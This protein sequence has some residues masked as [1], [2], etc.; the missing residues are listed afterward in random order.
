VLLADGRLAAAQAQHIVAR[1]LLEDAAD[2]FERSGAAYEA[3]QTRLELAT[4][5]PALG[6]A[7]AALA[8][9]KQA[10]AAVAALGA[11]ERHASADAGPL[12]QR[13]HEVLRLVAQGRSNDEIAAALVLSVRTV[14]RHVA[15]AYAKIGVSGRTARAAATAWAHANAIT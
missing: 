1:A 6:Y 14:E 13:E 8:A 4:S 5:L 7:P 15:N 11:R 12:T 3:A 9:E 10:R 2:A